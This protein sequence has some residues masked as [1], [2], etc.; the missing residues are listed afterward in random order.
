MSGICG[1]L[2]VGFLDSR[3]VIIPRFSKCCPAHSFGT[4]TVT[5]PI[6]ADY[7]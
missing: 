3:E 7:E 1:V 6:L 4:Y 2:A 5:V